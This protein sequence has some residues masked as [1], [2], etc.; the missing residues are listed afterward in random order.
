MI[1]SGRIEKKRLLIHFLIHIDIYAPRAQKHACGGNSIGITSDPMRALKGKSSVYL[2]NKKKQRNR[3]LFPLPNTNCYV[4]FY[5]LKTFKQS[6]LSHQ[7][8]L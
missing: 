5:L 8:E 6:S 2:F 7:I 4:E 1:A 3:I